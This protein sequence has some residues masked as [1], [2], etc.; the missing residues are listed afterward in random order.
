M[1]G[2]GS[3]EW[4]AAKAREMLHWDRPSKT[5]ERR[6]IWI[7]LRWLT[8]TAQVAIIYAGSECSITYSELLREVCSLANIL[9]STFGVKKGDTVSIYLP[10]TWHAAVAF[11][12]CARS[13]A[14]F[15]RASP[16]SRCVPRPHHERR[17]EKVIATVS[18]FGH[19]PAIGGAPQQWGRGCPRARDTLA[20]GRAHDLAG[21]RTLSRL[22]ISRRIRGCGETA[23]GG[24]VH[25]GVRDTLHAVH[26][27][28]MLRPLHPAPHTPHPTP[29]TSAQ[30]SPLPTS[31][32]R[33]EADTLR[34]WQFYGTARDEGGYIWIKGSIDDVINVSGHRLSTAEIESALITHMGVAE[35]AVI[36]T[37]DELTGQAVQ[38]TYD[39]HNEAALAK[40]LVLQV[41]KVIGPFAAPKIYIVPDLPKTRSGKG[42]A[43]RGET[44]F[45]YLP[46]CSTGP[47]S[48]LREEGREEGNLRNFLFGI[49]GERFWG[50][51]F[52][53]LACFLR[54]GGR[55]RSA[56]DCGLLATTRFGVVPPPLR[57]ELR[58]LGL[59]FGGVSSFE[60]GG[61]SAYVAPPLPPLRL[62]QEVGRRGE[63]K[64]IVESGEWGATRHS[65]SLRERG[66]GRGR[67]RGRLGAHHITPHTLS[68][69]RVLGSVGEP[70]NP[71]V[72]NWYKEHVCIRAREA[73]NRD[74]PG[75]H[76]ALP[77]CRA[78]QA[79]ESDSAVLWAGPGDIGS[80]WWG[81]GFASLHLT[82]L[83]SLVILFPCASCYRPSSSPSLPPPSHLPRLRSP[84]VD[85]LDPVSRVFAMQRTRR[86]ARSIRSLPPL[87][88]YEL[89]GNSVEGVLALV[90]PWPSIACT[91]WQDHARHLETY[92]RSWE[93]VGCGD[94]V[95]WGDTVLYAGGI[96]LHGR[97]ARDEDGYIWIKGQIDGGGGA[98]RGAED[99]DALARPPFSTSLVLAHSDDPKLTPLLLICADVID[100]SGHQLSTAKI[101]SALIMHKGVAETAVI[102]TADGLRGQAVYAF[103]MLEPELTYDTTSKA[104]LVKELMLQVRKVIG[105]FAAPKIYIVP[106][107]PKT[108]SGKIMRCIMRKI[109]A[110]EDE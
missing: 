11:L 51:A 22:Y 64:E 104:A 29:H 23:L 14:S 31:T 37:V 100:V 34:L 4:E 56:S 38:S 79:P 50:E 54:A 81:S 102:G 80:D 88:L 7:Q 61:S 94:T 36:G 1:V 35:T 40:G 98:V 106:D 87:L 55:F 58:G 83:A 96:L 33:A 103:V 24:Y 107:L 60:L 90:T 27:Y 75:R 26:P 8:R 25:C 66:R 76:Y 68:S 18:F 20:L 45:R 6:W 10:I 73:A 69:L 39:T 67:G 42:P 63:A 71:E 30:S 78:H 28:P 77:W 109:V 65:I 12:A 101:E 89:H 15:L 47:H 97:Q 72:W 105:P 95:H 62:L 16:P 43:G 19:V 70:I 5:A 57:L 17:G 91:I 9:T 3:D 44:F 21:P 86:S 52:A 110:G 2:A 13:T 59:A 74:Q 92:I 93:T 53:C 46:S 41:R 108:R 85:F 48:F 49:F 84:P 82:G 99:Y 32:L